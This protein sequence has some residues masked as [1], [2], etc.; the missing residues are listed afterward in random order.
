[1]ADTAAHLEREVLP[2]VPIRH[3]ISSLPWGL[4]ALLGYARELCAGVLSAFVAELSRSLKWR[5]KKEHGLRSVA[6]A[7]SG[8]VAAVQRVDSAV[9][10]SVHYHVLA[11]D[12]VYVREDPGDAQS[13]LV[14]RALPAPTRAEVAEVA[15]RT[16]QRVE[17]LLQARGRSLDP[18]QSD[19]EPV[20][21]QL[22]HPALS[23][24]YDAAALGIAVSRDR[25]G[26]PTLRL[27]CS[28]TTGPSAAESS[29]QPVAE[30]SGFTPSAFLCTCVPS[31]KS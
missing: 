24:C 14:F 31:A 16:A 26:Q 5:A 22:E 6:D 17:K 21:L 3:G 11:L 15:R 4:R 27:I 19:A 29:A 7:F 18:E 30:V 10:L 13:P 23:A 9:R 20:E 8:A 28:D 1:M 2:D 25:A 12:G